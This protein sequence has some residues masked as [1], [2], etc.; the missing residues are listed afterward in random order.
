MFLRPILTGASAALLLAAAAA[1]AD[2]VI[3]LDAAPAPTGYGGYQTAPTY[4]YGGANYCPAGTQPIV[5]AGV[6][7]CG[8]PTRAGSYSDMMRHPVQTRRYAPTYDDPTI[9]GTGG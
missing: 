4:A 9:K 7:C 2:E 1:R 6:I 5:L 3:Y 8:T